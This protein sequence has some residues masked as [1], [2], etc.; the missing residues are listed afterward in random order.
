MQQYIFVDIKNYFDDI[1]YPADQY[2][3]DIKN[4]FDDIFYPADH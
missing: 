2:S 1:F 3:A 4:Y